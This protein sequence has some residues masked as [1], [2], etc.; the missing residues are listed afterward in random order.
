MKKRFITLMTTFA[1]IITVV[2]AAPHTQCAGAT[3]D[4]Y[5][6]QPPYQY[7]GDDA[8]E[9]VDREKTYYFHEDDHDMIWEFNKVYS[10]SPE[11]VKSSFD[12]QEIRNNADSASVVCRPMHPETTPSYV[13]TL[14]EE[15]LEKEYNAEPDNIYVADGLETPYNL[16]QPM[17]W[18]FKLK[19]M[20]LG[21]IV[22]GEERASYT[23]PHYDFN[24][25]GVIMIDDVIYVNKIYSSIPY[26]WVTNLE[27]SQ[28]KHQKMDYDTFLE[29]LGSRY[30]RTLEEYPEITIRYGEN[31]MSH[32]VPVD[33]SN[34]ESLRGI[35][36]DA[37]TTP[38]AMQKPAT[39]NTNVEAITPNK[40]T[41]ANTYVKA[42]AP[43]EAATSS[44][45]IEAAIPMEETATAE[46]EASS[47][48]ATI[49]NVVEK[50]FAK[51]ANINVWG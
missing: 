32:E 11:Y 42:A 50:M 1:S 45:A 4:G 19:D 13:M 38:A 40:E 44:T 14:T 29:I 17:W 39:A 15:D 3:E 27:I 35:T 7:I 30:A 26:M 47:I 36:T 20:M 18:D 49:F 16:V 48:A 25:D 23:V 43:E 28:I 33:E 41:T 21:M 9:F 24:H 37:T 2:S 51:I 46:Y 10:L 6:E 34:F 12:I 31:W 8:V 5:P 22:N